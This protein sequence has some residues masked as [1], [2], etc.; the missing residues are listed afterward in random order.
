MVYYTPAFKREVSD[1]L[2]V[3]RSYVASTNDAL[4]KS[5]LKKV[6]VELHCIE[7]LAVMDHER[8]KTTERLTT[9]ER[10]KGSIL[11]LLNTADVAMLVTKNGVSPS[12]WSEF[13]DD[14][15]SCKFT[16]QFKFRQIRLDPQKCTVQPMLDT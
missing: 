11:K 2:G 13:V 12:E 10:A 7:E 3:I 4:T 16:S 1:P 14:G 8:D 9:F 6:R 5:R 15:A